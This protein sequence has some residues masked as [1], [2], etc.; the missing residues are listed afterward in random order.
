LSLGAFQ[1]PEATGNFL[2]PLGI[3]ALLLAVVILALTFRAV[4]RAAEPVG[5]VIDAAQRVAE[6][7]YNIRV[8]ERGPREVRGLTH[9]FNEMTE[10]LETN[11]A[12][13]RRLLADVSHELRTP[14]TI[15]QG[16]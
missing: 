3:G 14:L 16:N 10:R 6:G 13:R 7:D 4:R 2:R 15:I 1:L 5:D 9:A 11:D 8:Q 12:L